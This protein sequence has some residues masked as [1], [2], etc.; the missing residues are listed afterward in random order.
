MKNALWFA[1]L[2][3]LA[4]GCARP[5]V[6]EPP[7]P[8]P[9]PLAPTVRASQRPVQ[10]TSLW[11]DES[12]LTAAYE[13]RRARQIGDLVTVE[14]V[15]SSEASRE[16]S[17]DVSRDS[18]VAAGIDNLVGVDLNVRGFEPK[19]A[20][21]TA[22]SF[23]GSGATKRKDLLRTR[24]A[25]RVV[26]I[27]EDGNLVLEGRR[28]VRVNEET[29]YLFVRGIARPT[30]ISPDNTIASAALADAQVLYGGNGLVAAQ[31]KPGWLYRVADAVWPF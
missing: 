13:D 6:Q 8:A 3:C 24:V 27:L 22:N 5:Y 1:G 11:V 15:E 21:S 25:A 4:V 30:D 23:K 19:L 18:S 29:Q 28:Q 12:P 14:V 26:Q 2:L 9:T 31:Q 20:A 7:W 16:A 17:T 10:A